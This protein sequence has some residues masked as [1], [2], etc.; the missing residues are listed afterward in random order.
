MYAVMRA[1]S[2]STRPEVDAQILRRIR[3]NQLIER[4]MQ[5]GAIARDVLARAHP[6]VAIQAF[7]RHFDVAIVE[8]AAR[9]HFLRGIL[10]TRSGSPYAHFVAGHVSC[11]NGSTASSFCAPCSIQ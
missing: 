7:D 11:V 8:H 2:G 5:H 6:A 4:V 1:A 10:M 9:R 3:R